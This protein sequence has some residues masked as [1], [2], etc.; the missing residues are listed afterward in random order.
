MTES[1]YR[2]PMPWEKEKNELHDFYQSLIALRRQ[3]GAL[4]KGSFHVLYTEDNLIIYERAN[5]IEKIYV[6]IN[7]SYAKKEVYLNEL[8]MEDM[9]TVTLKEMSSVIII[10]RKMY[11]FF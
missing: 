4:Q 7:N 9:G 6:I 11:E 3:H 2:S 10:G 8:V 1:E 5:E